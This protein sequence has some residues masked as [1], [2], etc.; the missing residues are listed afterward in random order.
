MLLL[1]QGHPMA[2]QDSVSMEQLGELKLALPDADFGIRRTFDNACR[3]AGLNF[4][5][6]MQSNSFEALRDFVRVGSGGSI[7]P[8]R[9]AMLARETSGLKIVPIDHDAFENTTLDLIVVKQRRTPRIIRL[10]VETLVACI[11]ADNVATPAHLAVAAA[12]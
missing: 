10:F 1:P 8:R 7:L 6:M 12:E 4:T 11:E 2:N 9:A 3:T 5:P